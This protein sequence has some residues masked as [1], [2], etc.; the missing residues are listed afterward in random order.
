MHILLFVDED[1]GT[2]GFI[3]A[4][5]LYWNLL[6]ADTFELV[7]NLADDLLR[8]VCIRDGEEWAAGV[9]G[10]APL[11]LLPDIYVSDLIFPEEQVPRT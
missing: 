8:G 7:V 9:C 1:E 6:L 10:G 2:C 3:I 4:D 11:D 5:D